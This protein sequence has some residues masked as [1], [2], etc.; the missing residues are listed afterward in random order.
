VN[1]IV[2]L[3]LFAIVVEL[4]LVGAGAVAWRVQAGQLAA[5]L[6]RPL[7]PVVLLAIPMIAGTV[8]LL[9]GRVFASERV[10]LAEDH[11]RHLQGALVFWFVI[12]AAAQAWGVRLYLNGEPP[13]PDRASFLRLACVVIGVAM[14]VRGNF[15]AKLSPPTG[16]DA[17]APTAWTRTVLRIG[18]GLT[19]SGAVLIAAALV[20]PARPLFFVFMG[21]APVLVGLG[22]YQQ[23]ELQRGRSQGT[24]P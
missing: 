16:P 14:A 19:L 12:L 17:P 10:R 3:L 8:L 15:F 11:A 7:R 24:R 23:R 20:L 22:L 9:A 2:R 4:V 13:A 6:Q 5:D 18:W 21:A 1:R